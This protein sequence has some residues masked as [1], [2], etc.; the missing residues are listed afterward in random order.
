MG[1]CRRS[2]LACLAQRAELHAWLS[3]PDVGRIGDFPTNPRL[4]HTSSPDPPVTYSCGGA[5]NTT[6]VGDTL[7]ALLLRPS[8]LPRLGAG[9]RNPNSGQPLPALWWG[10][11]PRMAAL[12]LLSGCTGA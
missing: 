3:T 8:P 2:S 10:P 4:S 7:G 12:V 9:R 6:I 1:I 11:Q 5:P